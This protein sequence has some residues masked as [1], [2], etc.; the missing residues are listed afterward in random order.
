M[1]PQGHRVNAG[2]APQA[3]RLA[4]ILL[5]LLM[6]LGSSSLFAQGR[7]KRGNSK[8]K[9]AAAK[10]TTKTKGK[11][12]GKIKRFDFSAME[13]SGSER[14]PQLLYFLERANEELARA[15]L[16]RRSFIPEMIRSLDEEAL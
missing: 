9:P 16:E 4:C 12:S 8:K 14:K 13:L 1:N 11:R 5:A 15:S 7:K 3:K 2:S 10:K 6:V